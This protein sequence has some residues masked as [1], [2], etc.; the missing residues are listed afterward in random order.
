MRVVRELTGAP[1]ASLTPETPLMEAGVD[2][3][4]ATEL[5]SRLRSLTGVA[6][7]P[8]IVFEQPTPRAVAAHLLEQ[9][10]PPAAA[11]ASLGAVPDA[12]DAGVALALVGGT[13]RWAGGGESHLARWRLQLACADAMG[14][15]PLTR[16]ALEEIADTSALTSVQ[17]ACVRHG[18]FVGGAQR[19]DAAA[20]S[21]SLAEAG[22]MDPQQRLLLELGYA[23]LHGSSQRRITLMGCDV[24]VLLGI[25]RPDWALAQPPLARGSV[26]AVTGDNVSAAA[27]RVSFALGL[28]GPCSSVDTA[29]SSALAAVHWGGYAIRGGES[30][31]ALALAVSLKLTPHV[32][33]GAASAGMLSVDGRCKTLDARA[34]GYARSEGVGALVLREGSGAALRLCGS[35]VRQDGRSASLTAPNGSA[36]RTLLVAALERATLGA[37]DVGSIEAHGTGTA[38]GDPTEAGALAAVHGAAE[39]P[40]SIVYGA[41][42][43]SVGHTEASSG[44]VGLLRLSEMADVATGNAH[45]RSLNPLVGSRL[46]SRAGCFVLSSQAVSSQLAC[47]VS[48]FWY[49]GTI[50]HAVLAFGSGGDREAPAFGRAADPSDALAFG[51]PGAEVAGGGVAVFGAKCSLSTRALHSCTVDAPSHGATPPLPLVPHARSCTRRAGPQRPL[52]RPARP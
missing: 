43:A 29:C 27:G 42:K 36:Q 49:S 24:G 45:L 10:S 13:G 52:P 39:N 5:S 47:G 35:A 34:N 33:L 18:G 25:E 11:S 51:T 32:T 7:S 16:W 17:A 4:A 9:A 46:G 26:Y 3:L 28:Q 19:F 12:A 15:V 31:A 23:A 40:R 20:F 37:F 30:R 14:S 8:T 41:A 22:A 2:S 44:Q 21:L 1:A 6:L 48:S 38:L 50:A